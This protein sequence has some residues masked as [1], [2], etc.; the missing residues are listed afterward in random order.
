MLDHDDD[1]LWQAVRELLGPDG[2]LTDRPEGDEPMRTSGR[3]TAEGLAAEL[4][5]DSPE[6]RHDDEAPAD[7]VE[8]LRALLAEHGL[9]PEEARPDLEGPAPRQDGGGLSLA[10]REFRRWL[11]SLGPGAALSANDLGSLRHYAALVNTVGARRAAL[12]IDFLCGRRG[13]AAALSH[14]LQLAAPAGGMSAARAAAIVD[15]QLK[16]YP[17]AVRLRGAR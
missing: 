6:L 2:T 13:T 4:L 1:T 15:G 10:D 14:E 5:K 3:W 16:G 9:T 12:L 11:N 7:F 8:R 17:D